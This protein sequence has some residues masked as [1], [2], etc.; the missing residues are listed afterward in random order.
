MALGSQL[1]Q[2]FVPDT[3][4]HHIDGPYNDQKAHAHAL[5]AVG[6]NKSKQAFYNYMANV[7]NLM[8]P[9]YEH[10]MPAPHPQITDITDDNDNDAVG[11]SLNAHD[12]DPGPTNNRTIPYSTRHDVFRRS[13]KDK[14][15]KY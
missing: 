8:G 14:I 1:I 6:S 7:K 11:L 3:V 2:A 12:D 4:F 5:R 10:N 13:T 15:V 9:F